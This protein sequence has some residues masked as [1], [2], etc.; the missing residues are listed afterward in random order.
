MKS[1]RN[2]SLGIVYSFGMI[3]EIQDNNGNWH[4]FEDTYDTHFTPRCCEEIA[5]SYANHEVRFANGNVVRSPLQNQHSNSIIGETPFV[6]PLTREL[7]NYIR[8]MDNPTTGVLIGTRPF[9]EYRDAV[10]ADLEANPNGRI[11]V[12]AMINRQG[13]KKKK[14]YENDR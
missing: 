1:I 9:P 3:S 11:S 14:D 12:G 5:L 13:K 7:V 2:D 6:M 4:P 8:E 10:V